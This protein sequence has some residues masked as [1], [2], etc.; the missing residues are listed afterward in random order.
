MGIVLSEVPDIPLLSIYTKDVPPF[1]KDNYLHNI[2]ISQKTL[3]NLDV[4]Q[5][6]NG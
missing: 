3:N 5:L 4:P 2:Y 1:H 6:E